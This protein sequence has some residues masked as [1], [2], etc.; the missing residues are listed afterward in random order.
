MENL[1][2]V[3][4][5]LFS[6]FGSKLKVFEN[7]TKLCVIAPLPPIKSPTTSMFSILL[8]FMFF[9]L[10]FVNNHLAVRECVINMSSVY[11]IKYTL[12]D[13]YES[14]PSQLFMYGDGDC[15]QSSIEKM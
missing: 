9:A 5:T 12:F 8:F 7:W 14:L 4:E 13:C 1:R 3:K 6:N 11:T 10:I 2:A 15:I